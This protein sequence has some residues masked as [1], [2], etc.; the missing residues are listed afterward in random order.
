MNLYSALY[1]HHYIIIVKA[2]I[3]TEVYPR[4]TTDRNRQTRC[5]Y[6]FVLVYF[7]FLKDSI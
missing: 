4:L 5:T 3:I 7:H 1:R 2:I 6:G